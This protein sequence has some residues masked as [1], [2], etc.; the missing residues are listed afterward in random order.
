MVK[1]NYQ[2][3]LDSLKNCPGLNERGKMILYRC[4]ERVVT[5]ASFQPQ[6]VLHKPKYEKMCIAWGLS[7]S[8]TYGGAKSTLKSLSKY[9]EP[10]YRAIAKGVVNDEDG[11]KYCGK[12]SGHYT[13]F[14]SESCDLISKF[15]IIEEDEK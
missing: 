8:T 9:K 12:N 14:P 5:L 7:V 13:Y 15:E 4:V 6:A 1:I 11:V 3:K 10:E 2:E